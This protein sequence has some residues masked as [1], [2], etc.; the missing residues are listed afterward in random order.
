MYIKNSY[1]KT[2]A[3]ARV[4]VCVL[5]YMAFVGLGFR[6][7]KPQLLG[8]STSKVAVCAELGRGLWG[9]ESSALT[10]SIGFLLESFSEALKQP[11]C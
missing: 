7:P 2:H 4:C 9:L 10:L 6:S 11:G 8:K 3:R 1:R 5:V